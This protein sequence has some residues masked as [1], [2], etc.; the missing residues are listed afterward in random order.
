M[1]QDRKNV[2]V[3]LCML[4]AGLAYFYMTTALPRRGAVDAAFFPYALSIGMM[5]LGALHLALNWR[6][7]MTALGEPVDD[8][9]AP[10]AAAGDGEDA[11]AVIGAK[12]N[13]KS[14]GIS[15]LLIALFIAL[16]RPLGFA[17]SAALYLFLQFS[18][19]SPS[20]RRRPHLMHAVLA[21]GVSVIIF[22]LF[23]Y[24][25]GLMLPA[26]PLNRFIP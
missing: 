7:K 5:L 4:S 16:M 8:R 3:G 20:S 10:I 12:P 11:P 1:S 24:G 18:M 25:F 22:T 2:I 23:R 6:S 14:V 17:L 21:I 19:L 9:V 15:L 13:Y 26:G